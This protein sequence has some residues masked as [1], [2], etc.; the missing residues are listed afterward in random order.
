MVSAVLA[1]VVPTVVNRMIKSYV[2]KDVYKQNKGK[3]SDSKNTAPGNHLNT[4]SQLE[5]T[6]P[7]FSKLIGRQN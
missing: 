6:F 3:V 7:E 1:Y 2:Q 4:D 5:G